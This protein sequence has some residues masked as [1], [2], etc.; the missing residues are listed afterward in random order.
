[1]SAPDPSRRSAINS[2]WPKAVWQWGAADGDLSRDYPC[3]L[4]IPEPDQE[5]YR[6]VGVGAP[7]ATLFLWI[8]QLRLA[9]YSYDRIDNFGHQSPQK[10]V[11]GI[12]EL[13]PGQEFMRIFRLDSFEPG[14]SVTLRSKS[15][16]L[17]DSAVTYMALDTPGGTGSSAGS[18]LLVK[19]NVRYTSPL[20]GPLRLILPPGDLVMMRRQ[21][22]ELKRL[23]EG[24]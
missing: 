10:L 12:D 19:F 8:C 2:I 13:E 11:P 20:A 17:V 9:P 15:D 22:L 1:M 4:L 14:R 6:S 18:R 23:A 21:L 7:A 16:R 3:D 24:R 5:M